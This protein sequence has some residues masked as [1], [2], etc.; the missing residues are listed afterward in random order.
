MRNYANDERVRERD[1]EI[2][3]DA[4]EMTPEEETA[5]AL[6]LAQE[7]WL[8]DLR[9]RGFVCARCDQVSEDWELCKVCWD[10]EHDEQ[11]FQEESIEDERAREQRELAELE[12]DY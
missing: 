9:A 3:R 4:P 10:Q 12:E 1:R 5:L 8:A 6:E 2:P 11:E 7:N